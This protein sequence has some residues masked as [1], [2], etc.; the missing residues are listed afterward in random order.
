MRVYLRKPPHPWAP[1]WLIVGTWQIS[2]CGEFAEWFRRKFG[3]EAALQDVWEAMTCPAWM[4]W[5]TTRTYMPR[6]LRE[7]MDGCQ[8]EVGQATG[9]RLFAYGCKR[10]RALARKIRLVMPGELLEAL[11]AEAP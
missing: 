6:Y 7:L 2:V 5:V 10:D 4:L 9:E 11:L 3:E 8:S 1:I